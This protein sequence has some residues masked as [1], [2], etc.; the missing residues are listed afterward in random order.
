MEL[1]GKLA[2]N[3]HRIFGA[4]PTGGIIIGH[5]VHFLQIPNDFGGFVFRTTE[6]EKESWSTPLSDHAFQFAVAEKPI[7]L[8]PPHQHE[9]RN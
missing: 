1:L 3:G 4:Q 9:D 5:V 7:L 8:G 6:S 2:R